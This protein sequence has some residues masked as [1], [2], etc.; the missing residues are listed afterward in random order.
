MKDK[1]G[2]LIVDDDQSTRK[3]LSLIFRKKG[4]Q[5][6]MAGTG[7]QALKKVQG[8]IFN[9]ALLDIKLPDIDGVELLAP[10]KKIQ[11]DMAVIMVTAYASV[12]TAILALNQG[13][14]FYIT[15]PLNM[16]EVLS[17]IKEVLEKQRLVIE[18]RL[19]L[20]KIQQ[21][22]TQR[23]QLEEQMRHAQKME[24]VGRLAGGVAHD[25]N[26]LLTVIIGN[27]QLMMT[28]LDQKDP[29][30]KLA[31]QIEQACNRAESLTRQLLAISRKQVLQPKVLNINH[32]VGKMEK[33]LK[34]LIRED[35]ALVILPDPE[36]GHIRADRGQVEQVFLNLVVNAKDAMPKGGKLTIRTKNIQLKES[37]NWE[38]MII[39]IGSYIMISVSDTG[40]GMDKETMTYIFDPFFTTKKEG[41][42]TG[43]GLSTV[44]GIVKQSGGYINVYSEPGKGTTVK[45]Y[46]P[47][48]DEAVEDIKDIQGARD[49]L[50]GDEAI[51]VVEDEEVVRNFVC[52]IL[53]MHGYHVLEAPHGG[54]ALL[55]CERYNQPIHL[56]L[57]DVFMP[58]LSGRELVERL[59]SYHQEMKVLYMSGYADDTMFQHGVLEESSH[60]IQKPFSPS[61]LLKKIR[62]I[63]DAND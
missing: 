60:F 9:L 34:R 49:S 25:F 46:F 61:A 10:M 37:L 41:E 53:R 32:V 18:N 36:I 30:Y 59:M 26:N 51:L 13:A 27:C 44:Y 45:I 23:K 8:K 2:I 29:L 52:H 15:K 54:S 56:I 16:D 58:E 21:E 39:P 47:V 5:V 1:T 20:Q 50:K 7:R 35:I 28:D 17:T 24:A 42:G 12:E 57:T 19:L 3:S 6:E 22:F 62:D 14:S 4:Y 11:P 33:M 48:T 55:K 38:D 43:L 63:L 31:E 40:F